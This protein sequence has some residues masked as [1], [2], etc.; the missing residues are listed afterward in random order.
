MAKHMK[1]N[2]DF[3]KNEEKQ[4]KIEKEQRKREGHKGSIFILIFRII[5]LIIIAICIYKLVFWYI[6]NKK[7]NDILNDII[8]EQKT[9]EIVVGDET[10]KVLRHNFDEL[11]A[12]NGDTVGW[13]IVKGT[14]INYPIVHC[15]DNDFYLNHSFDK[16]YNSAGWIFANYINKFDGTDKNISIFGHN[17]RDGSMFCTLKDTIKK[18][19]YTNP[20]NYIITFD[21]PSKLETYKVFSNYQIRSESYY[22]TNSFKDEQEY[23]TFL[24]TITSRSVYNY[25]IK[26][27][28]ND[29][30]ITLST[31]ANDNTYRVV[32][33]AVKVE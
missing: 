29:K 21:T 22:L 13:L 3:I 18:D 10:I 33:H 15:K 16:S 6:E 23:K 1:K 7:N 2:K 27:N 31:C 11:L 17:R 5:S 4:S 14:K 25:G 24:D 12:K 26:P 19:W 20:D 9:E 30:I 32:L 28:V 8:S